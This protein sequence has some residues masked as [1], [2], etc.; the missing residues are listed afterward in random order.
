M[1]SSVKC[2][3]Y[4]PPSF[5]SFALHY[6]VQPSLIID[7]LKK[8]YSVHNRIDSQTALFTSRKTWGKIYSKMNTSICWS[9]IYSFDVFGRRTRYRAASE[10]PFQNM[11]R[12]QYTEEM[13]LLPQQDVLVNSSWSYDNSRP[14]LG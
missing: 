12:K 6:Y 2:R 13:T 9:E 14:P 7:N 1:D 4:L 8:G 3:A 10:L 11:I 5:S